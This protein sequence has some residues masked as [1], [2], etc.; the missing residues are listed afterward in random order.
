MAIAHDRVALTLAREIGVRRVQRVIL[1]D[2]A[3]G[4]DV[5][6]NTQKF[7]SYML[8]ALAIQRELGLKFEEAEALNS[9]GWA[10]FKFDPQVSLDYFN[11]SLDIYR[12]LGDDY[13]QAFELANIGDDYRVLGDY[14]KA[15]DSFNKTLP[16][17]HSAGPGP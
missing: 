11:Q 8:Q 10:Y 3:L 6:D 7:V 1:R 17:L 5:P 9:L 13:M 14:R 16:L 15:I 4:Y 12:Q 2:M